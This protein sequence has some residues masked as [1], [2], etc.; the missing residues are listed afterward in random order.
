MSARVVI[1]SKFI[2]EW[3]EGI[4]ATLDDPHSS[5]F[6]HHRSKK[7]KYHH[8]PLSPPTSLSGSRSISDDMAPSLKTPSKKH[9]K[10]KVDTAHDDSDPEGN[11][12]ETPT[13]PPRA[14]DI[15]NSDVLSL[16]SA[17]MSQAS[18]KSSPT[19]LFPQLSLAPQGLKRVPMDL[20][21]PNLPTDLVDLMIEM[22][23]ICRGRGVVPRSLKST[24]EERKRESRADYIFYSEFDDVVYGTDDGFSTEMDTLLNTALKTVDAAVDCD[25]T[26][27]DE[28]GW[29]HLVHSPLLDTVLD[30]IPRNLV[31]FAPCMTANITSRYKIPS[32]PGARVDYAMFANPLKDGDSRL[33]DAIENLQRRMPEASINH[34]P[35]TPFSKRPISV[36]IETKRQNGEGDKAVLQIGIWQAA[37]W[38]LLSELTES[39]IEDLSFIPGIVVEGHEWKLVATTH[40]AGKTVRDT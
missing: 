21:D 34:T 26:Q 31:G 11:E 32:A 40:R 38:N 14:M 15:D 22:Q 17:S 3:L 23:A 33:D 37:Q 13:Q 7:R 1:E 27:Q 30:R 6:D 19:K 2:A 25:A 20:K 28:T 35:F 9:K 4:P 8:H 18:N 24:I 5:Q 10:R 39:R 36:S 12:E 29:N 16:S